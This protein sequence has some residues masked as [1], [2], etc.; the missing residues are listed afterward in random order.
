MNDTGEK[1][2]NAFF[3]FFGIDRLCLDLDLLLLSK[4]SAPL[5]SITH[6]P[7]QID[8]VTANQE[9]REKMWAAADGS[10]EIP[11]LHVDGKVRGDLLF[12]SSP[13]KL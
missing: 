7:V 3:T 8:L 9:A 2:E 13:F 10:R 1:R 12:L 5:P 6:F 4:T 11:Q